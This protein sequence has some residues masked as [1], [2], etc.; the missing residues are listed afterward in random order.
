MALRVTNPKAMV[1]CSILHHTILHS[2]ETIVGIAMEIAFRSGR[3]LKHVGVMQGERVPGILN[4]T[5]NATAWMRLLIC[6]L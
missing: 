5:G 1:R 4:K 6:Q 3:P 2:V